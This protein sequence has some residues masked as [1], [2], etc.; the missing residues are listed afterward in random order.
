MDILVCDKCGF[1]L[2][3]I[4]DIS[5]AMEGAD[6]WQLACRTRGVAPR[7]VFPCK[8][9]FQCQGEMVTRRT[10]RKLKKQSNK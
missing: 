1:E 3:E 9:Y 8:F 7:G 10:N 5:L 4:D 2:T 6:A